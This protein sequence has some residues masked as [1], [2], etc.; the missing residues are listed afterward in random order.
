MIE[1]AAPLRH[2]HAARKAVRT[3]VLIWKLV[4]KLARNL[5]YQNIVTVNKP[6][7]MGDIQGT[8]PCRFVAPPAGSPELL[9]AKAKTT[10]AK[11]AKALATLAA[12]I[13]R[14]LRCLAV[15]SMAPV[16]PIRLISLRPVEVR[17]L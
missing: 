16:R 11:M 7:E 6:A 15:T 4:S 10:M 8:T 3:A 2:A 17:S 14:P 13:G 12:V 1:D 9:I 5:N